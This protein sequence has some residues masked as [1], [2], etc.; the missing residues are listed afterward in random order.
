MLY[1]KG[2]GAWVG[3]KYSADLPALNGTHPN[4]R[5]ATG[6]DSGRRSRMGLLGQ[7]VGKSRV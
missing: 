7:L 4:K 6:L 2:G 1:A 3:N 5:Y